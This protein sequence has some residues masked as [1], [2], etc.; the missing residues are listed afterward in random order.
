[1]TSNVIPING[2]LKVVIEFTD[3]EGDV[4]DSL[5][6]KKR[7]INLR[8]TTTIRDSLRFKIPSFP[9]KTKGEMEVVLDYQSILSAINPPNI[10]GS[11]PPQKESDTLTLKFAVRDKQGNASDSLDLGT[12]IVLRN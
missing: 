12:I 5:F 10:P 4:D 6:I 9:D 2:A 7:R 11:N 8:T 1:M 3:K